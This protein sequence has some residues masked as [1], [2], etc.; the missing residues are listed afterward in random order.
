[1]KSLSRYAVLLSVLVIS[2]V[3]NACGTTTG[4]TT[5]GDSAS[6]DPGDGT[7][8][9]GTYVL[10]TEDCDP[11]EGIYVFT[12]TQTGSDLVLT[13]NEVDENSSYIAGD[14][15]AAEAKEIEGQTFATVSELECAA[16]LMTTQE[17][18]DD[19]NT[20]NTEN[21]AQLGDLDVFCNDSSDD[22]VCTLIYQH[23]ST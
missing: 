13:V 9:S 19:A 6:V 14:E 17:D 2:L 16:I 20:R 18:V 3:I 8:F 4:P 23:S 11:S 15:I 5:A 1:M 22:S 12:V 10:R 7:V 21:A